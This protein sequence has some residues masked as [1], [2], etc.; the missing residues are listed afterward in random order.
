[1]STITTRR[2]TQSP[3]PSFDLFTQYPGVIELTLAEF[4][5]SNLSF[6]GWPQHWRL[7]ILLLIQL[8]RQTGT[9]CIKMAQ[10]EV[11]INKLSKD[12]TKECAW[13]QEVSDSDEKDS[14]PSRWKCRDPAA[15]TPADGIYAY[16]AV[17]YFP[18]MSRPWWDYFPPPTCLLL[19]KN[20]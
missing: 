5:S 11:Y 1:M 16:S 4:F 20:R 9:I 8:L 12:L 18:F 6:C 13:A 14:P 2:T 15:P 7:L 19:K 10:Q 3:V 17:L